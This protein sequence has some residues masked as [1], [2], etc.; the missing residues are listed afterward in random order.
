MVDAFV[1]AARIWD[2]H[3]M[4]GIISKSEAETKVRTTLNKTLKW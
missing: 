3:Y 2:K 4:E 1:D